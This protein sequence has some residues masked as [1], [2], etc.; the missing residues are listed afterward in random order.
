[1]ILTCPACAKRYRVADTAVP[2]EGRSVRCAACGE[3]WFQPSGVVE[4]APAPPPPAPPAPPPPPPPATWEEPKPAP[5][6]SRGEG[7][8]EG[9]ERSECPATQNPSPNPPTA[10]G[11]ASGRAVGTVIAVIVGAVLLALTALTVPGGIAGLDPA[12][13]LAPALPNQVKLSID[14]PLIGVGID[15]PVSSPSSASSAIRRTIFSR[16]RRSM[17]TCATRPARS[18]PAGTSP[19]PLPILDRHA[20]VQFETAAGGIPR[21]AAHAQVRFALTTPK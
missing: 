10:R 13:R 2:P 1:M 4:V 8:G 20:T 19:P 14:A 21:R 11:R 16:F 5:S 17:S 6:P 7:W 3:S 15:G 9:R 12:A 18:S